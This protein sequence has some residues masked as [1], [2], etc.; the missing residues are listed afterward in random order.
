M[1][2]KGLHVSRLAN[3]VSADTVADF[4]DTASP[5]CSPLSVRRSPFALSLSKGA[6]STALDPFDKLRANGELAQRER[7]LVPAGLTLP[8]WGL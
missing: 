6:H 2:I 1:R 4:A 3:K 5:L 8:S 7:S